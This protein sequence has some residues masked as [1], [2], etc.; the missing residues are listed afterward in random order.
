MS[1]YTVYTEEN[2]PD[3]ARPLL[4]N[5]MKGFGFIPNLHG[6][7]AES[8]AVLEAYQ[9]MSVI[10]GKTGL[11]AVE[12]QVVYQVN[13][14]EA[15]CRYCVAAHTTISAFDKVPEDVTA[16]LRAGTELPDAK[17]NA[18]AVFARKVRNGFGHLA[19][20]DIAE[21]HAAGYTKEHLLGVIVLTATKVLSNYTNHVAGTPVDDRFAANAWEKPAAVAAE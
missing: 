2:A 18:L 7:M 4:E 20:V 14:F 6:V 17:L 1:D 11:N 10:A 21:F 16:A 15:G 19:D 13:N 9:T 5:S 8:P 12:R 3:A